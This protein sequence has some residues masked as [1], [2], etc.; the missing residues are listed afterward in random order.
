MRDE[1]ETATNLNA[2][3]RAEVERGTAHAHH[4]NEV[5]SN[6]H[7][8]VELVMED[9]GIGPPLGDAVLALSTGSSGADSSKRRD[10]G[11]YRWSAI[12]VGGR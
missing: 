5:G 11:C 12:P 3:P 10:M 7:G 1:V 8:V 2:T 6:D 4:R 9:Y